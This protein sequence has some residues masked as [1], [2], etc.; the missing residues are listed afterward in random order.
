VNVF[1]ADMQASAI[2]ATIAALS[3]VVAAFVSYHFSR[4]REIEADWRNQRLTQYR[5]L[6]SSLSDAA[7]HGINSNKAQERFANAFNTIALVAPQPDLNRLLEFHDEIRF[8]NPDPSRDRHDELLTRLVFEIRRDMHIRPKD[9]VES[10]R[11][12]LIGKPPE[13][14]GAGAHS[15]KPEKQ[16]K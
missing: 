8:G 10:F 2:T 1:L 4:K 15:T 13:H 12:R 5:E 14:R 9:D 3:S 16:A 11:F 6:L 7:I